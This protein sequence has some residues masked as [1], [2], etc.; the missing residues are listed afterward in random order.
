MAKIR[1]MLGIVLMV[2]SGCAVS[3]PSGTDTQRLD[4][5]QQA[6]PGATELRDV[7]VSEDA[8]KGRR[9]DKIVVNEIRGP[10]SV[11]GYCVESTVAA[12]SGPFRIR[13][14]GD[15]NG[16]VVQAHVVSYTWERGRDIRKSRFTRQFQGK[17]PEA[18]LQV[19]EDIDA[20]TGATLSSKAMTA[21]V[22]DS[23]ALLKTIQ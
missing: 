11:L 14:L 18:P 22:R 13:V 17:G 1:P 8:S 16:V 15:P 9:A 3:P 7:R 6:F 5:V 20:M 21:G 12:K 2:F 19:G 23:I 4:L 10:S